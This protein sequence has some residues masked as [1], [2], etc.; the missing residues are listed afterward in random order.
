MDVHI[1]LILLGKI[2]ASS[3]MG[4]MTAKMRETVI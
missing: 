2:L 3:T 4:G 1:L